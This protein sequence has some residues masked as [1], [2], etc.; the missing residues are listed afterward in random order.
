MPIKP[1]N[2]A[3]YPKDWPAISQR[4]RAR[5]GQACELCGVENYQLGAWIGGLWHRAVPKGDG[6][7]DNPRHGETFPCERGGSVVW[8][9]VR[10]IVLTVAHMDHRPE[11]CD[12]SNLKALCQR[13]H[14]SYDAKQHAENARRTRFRK[15]GQHDLFPSADAALPAEGEGA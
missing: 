6:L 15:M 1:E 11:N 12:D 13:C 2:K 14:L 9:R 8:T 10:R 3:R 5:A 7:R 4:V